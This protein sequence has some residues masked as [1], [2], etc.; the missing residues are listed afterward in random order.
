MLIIEDV[1]EVFIKFDGLWKEHKKLISD[2]DECYGGDCKINFDYLL[3]NVNF[4]KKEYQSQMF[5]DFYVSTMEEFLNIDGI[6]FVDNNW[7]YLVIDDEI[8]E[9]EE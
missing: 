3:N 7:G 4:Y 1:S 9:V 8:F 2:L 5:N 6:V